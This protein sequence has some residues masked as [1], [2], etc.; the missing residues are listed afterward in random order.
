MVVSAVATAGRPD[1]DAAHTVTAIAGET[2][3]WVSD[4]LIGWQR[5]VGPVR[6]ADIG[7]TRA[8]RR[9]GR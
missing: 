2:L 6:N 4:S 3:F 1:W 7:S 5:F 8:A 9:A